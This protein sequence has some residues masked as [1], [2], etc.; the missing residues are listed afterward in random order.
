MSTAMTENVSPVPEENPAREP[1]SAMPPSQAAEPLR[2]PARRERKR[3][4]RVLPRPAIAVRGLLAAATPEE[5]AKAKETASLVLELW[6]GK[7]SKAEVARRLKVA[8]L[9]AWQLSQQAL[10]G[11]IAGLL[12]QPRTRPRAQ[13]QLVRGG[14]S[15]LAGPSRPACDLAQLR[16]EVARLKRELV[17]SEQVNALLRQF[18]A[19]RQPEPKDGKRRSGRLSKASKQNARRR[20]APDRSP[21]PE[22]SHR[23]GALAGRG[24]EP[25][26]DGTDAAELGAAGA[27][28]PAPEGGP[29][30][31]RRAGEA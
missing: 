9:R 28:R 7:T 13:A 12:I 25:R 31:A 26:R 23:P 6:L 24:Q 3:A 18:P 29:P 19:T 17:A 16:R 22:R 1:A 2:T 27:V 4:F 5:L 30:A 21:A 10:S 15:L 11:M 20:A 8:P 14:L